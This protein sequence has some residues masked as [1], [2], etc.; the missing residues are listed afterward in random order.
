M[1]VVFERKTELLPTIWEFYFRPERPLNYVPGQYVD[2]RLPHDSPDSRGSS[3]T[4]T[5]TSLPDESLLSF[6]VKIVDPCSSYKQVLR[7]LE[8]GDEATITD[9]MGDVILPKDPSVPLLFVAGGLGI[10]SFVSIMRYLTRVNERRDIGLF[11][12]LRNKS[13]RLYQATFEAYQF[14][15]KTTLFASHEAQE[16]LSAKI[17]AEQ[18]PIDGLF[19]LSGSESFVESLLWDLKTHFKVPDE[20]LVY[21]FFSGYIE[22]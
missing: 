6:A 5:L 22:L 4:F 20:R 8:V 15:F 19:Y 13:D 18:L 3:R 16:R 2:L 7:N 1:R 10:A 9:A 21:D 12:A 17:I 11:Y 14:P